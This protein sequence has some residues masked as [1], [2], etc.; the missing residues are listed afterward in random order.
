M[1]ELPDPLPSP[2]VAFVDLDAIASNYRFLRDRVA[3]REII[4]VVKADAYG[5]GAPEVARRLAAEGVRRFAVA[6]SGEGIALRRA[7]IG[8]E[9]LVLS[10]AEPYELPELRAYGLTPSLYDLAQAEAMAAAASGGPRLPVHV[11]LDTGMGR[12]GIRPEDVD[13]LAGILA[14]SPSLEVAGTFANLSA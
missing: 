8:G 5:H 1:P 10:R 14:R 13:A 4:A 11:E 9:I 2:A 6:H 3:P 12:A 7:G